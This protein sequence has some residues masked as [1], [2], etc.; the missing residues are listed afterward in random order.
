MFKLYAQGTYF[1]R[2]QRVHDTVFHNARDCTGHHVIGHVG[3]WY[4][5]VLIKTHNKWIK[6]NKNAE[7]VER[8]PDAVQ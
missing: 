5:L 4:G 1:Y 8:A 2:V 6:I 7:L 3:R